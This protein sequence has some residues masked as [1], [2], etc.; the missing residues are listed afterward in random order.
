VIPTP[1]PAYPPLRASIGISDWFGCDR[2]VNGA[3]FSDID[4]RGLTFAAEFDGATVTNS[5]ADGPIWW[6]LELP[7]TA[8]GIGPGGSVRAHITAAPDDVFRVLDVACTVFD[9]DLWDERSVPA[10]VEG[11]GV[12]LE[13]EVAPTEDDPMYHCTFTFD[14][15]GVPRFPPSP[16][17]PRAPLNAVVEAIVLEGQVKVG[18]PLRFLSGWRFEPDFGDATIIHSRPTTG[19][20]DEP[21]AW[22]LDL[23]DESTTAVMSVVAPPGFVVRS[24]ACYLDDSEEPWATEFVGNR[25]SFELV[26]AATWCTFIAGRALPSTDGLPPAPPFDTGALARSMLPMLL[27][28]VAGLAVLRRKPSSGGRTRTCAAS[29]PAREP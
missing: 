17:P 21:A 28:L 22:D 7:G 18:R 1:N 13:F 19:G 9:V 29:D 10:T 27:G 8:M 24:V 11:N 14:P 16:V 2:V 5:N 12:V 23:V 15:D 4:S 25:L 26:P 3:C 6:S 20:D